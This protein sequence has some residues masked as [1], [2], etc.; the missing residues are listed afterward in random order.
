[1]RMIRQ[2]EVHPEGILAL[3]ERKVDTLT[4]G[5]WYRPSSQER[6]VVWTG[7]AW[8]AVQP[9]PPVSLDDLEAKLL[10]VR[11]AKQVQHAITLCAAALKP[12]HE[13]RIM[14]IR[15]EGCAETERSMP[16]PLTVDE[17]S[18]VFQVVHDQ[19]VARLAAI[20]R[21]LEL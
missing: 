7:D 12:E 15:A 3:P 14:S 19:L 1:M 20:K 21:D 16:L 4:P 18:A 10:R 13:T 8:V 9:A 5:D 6:P 2:V 17:T 11:E